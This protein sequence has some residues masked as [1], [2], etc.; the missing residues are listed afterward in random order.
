[1]GGWW[2]D[3]DVLRVAAALHRTPCPGY[4]GGGQ[5][6]MPQVPRWPRGPYNDLIQAACDGSV[7]RTLALLSMGSIDIDQGGPEGWTPLICS[8]SK[9]YARIV[10]ILLKAGANVAVAAD[11]GFT[12][13]HFAAQYD[14]LA[15]TK[16]LLAAGGVD[17]EL[18]TERGATPLLVAADTGH[19]EIA[20]ALIEAGANPNCRSP[21]GETPLYA[22]AHHGNLAVVTALLSAK[23][24][25]LLAMAGWPGQ[26]GPTPGPGYL[27]LDIAAEFGKLGVV[28]ELIQQ[29]GIEGCAG[30]TG[31]VLALQLA[32]QHQHVDIVA[33]LT[34]AGVVDTGG[35]LVAAA[36]AGLEASVKILLQRRLAQKP[37]GAGAYV[38]NARG[39]SGA[40]AVLLAAGL[41]GRCSPRILRLFVDVGA[42]TTSSV[43]IRNN[44][45]VVVGCG[46]PLRLATDSLRNKN[47]TE[48][49]LHRLEAVRRLLLRVDAVRATS[50]LWADSIGTNGRN[51]EPTPR[52]ETT[53]TTGSPL[54]TMQ[55]A[56]RRRAARHGMLFAPLFRW[57]IEPVG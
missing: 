47:A 44:R 56:L 41:A 42:D 35:A 17:L 8:V 52:A 3:R 1:M 31:G 2:V 53:P 6:I 9:G 37:G 32:A 18:Q 48:D 19:T 50:W 16:M 11:E 12:A 51:P 45:G 26:S 21:D 28:R 36:G 27:P 13:L 49:Q 15:V 22:A 4:L 25:P 38:D 7:E 33:A 43:L 10:R 29:C 55:P 46:S 34:D 14:H 20:T 24:D 5:T 23:A 39:P 57:V 30:E 40:T 54:T